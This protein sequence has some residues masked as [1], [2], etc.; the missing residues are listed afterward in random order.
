MTYASKRIFCLNNFKI[1]GPKS[2]KILPICLKSFCEFPHR[3]FDKIRNKEKTK[4]EENFN[5]DL[6]TIPGYSF[7][8]EN[9]D[10]KR[11]VGM[12]ISNSVRYTR[13]TDLEGAN[14][15][16]VIIDIENEKR[17]KK[18]LIN[19]YRSFNPIG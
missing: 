17:K 7:E 12:Y 13:C 16:L 15:H 9:N 10:V 18:R 11:R 3:N 14:N 6:L 4:I 2:T 1:L 5:C 19:F 8:Y